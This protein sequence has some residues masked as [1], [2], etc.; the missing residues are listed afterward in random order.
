MQP[1]WREK[2]P[3]RDMLPD[4]AYKRQ[5]DYAPKLAFIHSLTPPP[6][7]T[8]TTTTVT[9]FLFEKL[10]DGQHQPMAPPP[11]FARTK[12]VRVKPQVPK[13]DL[14][15]GQPRLATDQPTTPPTPT[16]SSVQCKLKFPTVS[17]CAKNAAVAPQRDLQDF[18]LLSSNN[19]RYVNE[20]LNIEHKRKFPTG[21]PAFLYQGFPV[22]KFGYDKFCCRRLTDENELE[23]VIGDFTCDPPGSGKW[24][25]GAKHVVL[26]KEQL[27]RLVGL[28]F[29]NFTTNCRDA[30]VADTGA[31][32]SSM[33]NLGK[34]VHF[35]W[36]A[37]ND[38][39]MANV[40]QYFR[41]ADGDMQATSQG[42]SLTPKAY[43]SFRT[44]IMDLT[45]MIKAEKVLSFRTG[46]IPPLPKP[47][48]EELIM[49]LPFVMF[50]QWLSRLEEKC[51]KCQ[52]LRL[53]FKEPLR[54][55]AAH[56]CHWGRTELTLDQCM[57]A[58]IF[59]ELLHSK[60]VF[61]MLLLLKPYGDASNFD[62]LLQFPI[63]DFLLTHKAD[64]FEQMKVIAHEELKITKIVE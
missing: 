15:G 4:A 43:D 5:E 9:S 56:T 47:N 45:L 46:P 54:R 64:L 11:K 38:T 35:V 39:A 22:M 48:L 25:P 57:K 34:E 8:T 19:K 27:L 3:F 59:R 61:G 29:N 10:C 52:Q 28:I 21:K 20:D 62:N 51:D 23:A 60:R 33:Y 41:R 58:E 32:L 26:N 7:A 42:V 55:D 50:K 30:K 37:Y 1:V 18:V 44:G 17:N 14:V 49:G 36:C 12:T 24:E 2:C 16:P 40:R 53:V 6:P 31:K 13:L 63:Q